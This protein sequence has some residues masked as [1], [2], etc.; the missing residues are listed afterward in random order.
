MAFFKER[1]HSWSGACDNDLAFPS[2]K[3]LCGR[4]DVIELTSWP[5]FRDLQVAALD[6]PQFAKSLL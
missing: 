4:L 3:L 5:V 2:D 1:G 6:P